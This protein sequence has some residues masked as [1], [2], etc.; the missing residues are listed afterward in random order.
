M[1]ALLTVLAACTVTP[2]STESCTPNDPIVLAPAAYSVSSTS[3]DAEQRKIANTIIGVAKARG[4]NR[5]DAVEGVQVSYQESR[6]RN[7]HFGTFESLGIFQQQPGWGSVA[8]RLNPVYAS[9]KFFAALEK[10]TNR[11]HMTPLEVAYAVQNPS[12]AAYNTPRNNFNSWR[13]LANSIVG[14]YKGDAGQVV[15]SDPSCPVGGQPSGQAETFV[16]YALTQVGKP[17]IF[18]AATPG[19]GFDCSGLTLWA[20]AKVGL[21][22]PHSAHLQYRYGTAVDREHLQRGDFVFWAKNTS[23]P[24]TIYH[25]GIYIGDGQ[26][27]SAP[28]PGAE[29]RV[30]PMYYSGG[31]IG[32]K[33]MFSS[34]ATV[35]PASQGW[36]SPLAAGSYRLSSPYGRRYHPVLHVWKLHDGQDMAAKEGTPIKAASGGTVMK[37]K[38]VYGYGNFVVI[39]HAGGIKSGYGHMVRFAPGIHPGVT[40][41]K[42]QIIGY[43][44]QTGLATGDHLHF[45]IWVNGHTV[46]PVPFMSEHGASLDVQKV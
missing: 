25:V 46:N 4:D 16:K 37:A 41:T 42:G 13:S 32:G 35:P 10:V 39:Q 31:F 8:N 5:D 33:R 7:I 24:N 43:V 45:M 15:G 14:T 29:V 36:Q 19:V 18:D 23:D 6:L 17:Y 28:H 2:A 21:K 9:N 30:R 40:V 44:G 20:A 26:L 1:S 3:L 27:L 34:T 11:A 38:M 12:H 22:L